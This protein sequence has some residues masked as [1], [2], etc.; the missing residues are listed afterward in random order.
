MRADGVALS[1]CA[2]T[3][4]LFACDD[5]DDAPAAD[6]A[7]DVGLDAAEAGD[8]EPPDAL[9]PD[10]AVLDAATPD[11]LQPDAAPVEVTAT[12]ESGE[13]RGVELGGVASFLG[14]PY[15]APPVGELR[16]RPPEPPVAW[17]GVRDALERGSKCA[18]RSATNPAG[19]GLPGH[20][21]SPRIAPW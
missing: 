14:V 18:Q 4:L 7:V 11:A 10:G 16:W 21:S 6:A 2:V 3:A 1:L 19:D 15:A 9:P 5:G 17:E 20:S 13:L 12:V 8:S